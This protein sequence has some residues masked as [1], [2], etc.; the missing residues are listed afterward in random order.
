[1]NHIHSFTKSFVILILLCGTVLLTGCRGQQVSDTASPSSG[2]E[3]LSPRPI[4]WSL[5]TDPLFDPPD[6]ITEPSGKW[7]DPANRTWQGASPG[8]ARTRGGRLFACL[9]SGGRREPE[10]ANY[11]IFML[12]D[13]DGETWID[14]FLIV[15]HPHNRVRIFDPSVQ[16]DPLGRLWLSWNQD[17]SANRPS[18]WGWWTIRIDNPDLPLDELV[19]TIS[20]TEP[21]RISDG[22]K[23]NKFIVLDNGDWLQPVGTNGNAFINV[24]AS[25]DQGDTWSLRGRMLGNAKA[26]EPMMVQK[27]DGRLWLLSRL[28]LQGESAQVNGGIGQSFSNDNG[29]NWLPLEEN[30]PDPIIGPNSRF[31]IGRLKSGALL[32]ITNASKS[33]RTNMTAYL[34]YD[35]GLSWPYSLLLDERAGAGISELRISAAWDGPSYPDSVEDE[36]GRIYV[37]WDFQRY[38]SME[39][40]LSVFTEDDVKAASFV[41]AASR[42]RVVVSRGL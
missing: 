5:P 35:D 24:Y 21:V 38:T 39:L 16:V 30:L 22:L 28:W 3:V 34:S 13:D 9:F 20:E 4:V 2:S 7:L 27:H 12:S 29:V 40:L 42:S 18:Q 15:D 31:Y 19:K 36:E 14:P 25:A 26:L 10:D 32:F 37:V 1:M 23:I 11:A 6:I 8:I 41:S 33:A 17:N